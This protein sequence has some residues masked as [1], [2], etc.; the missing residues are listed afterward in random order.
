MTTA[1]IA[2]KIAAKPPPASLNPHFFPLNLQLSYHNLPN[3]LPFAMI[4]IEVMI[5]N[6]KNGIFKMILL[7]LLGAFLA[8]G[9]HARQEAYTPTKKEAEGWQ[10]LAPIKKAFWLLHPMRAFHFF[11]LQQSLALTWKLGKKYLK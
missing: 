7:A 4:R 8:K 10:A 5:V 11:L 1:R 6:N 3:A 2:I 9:L